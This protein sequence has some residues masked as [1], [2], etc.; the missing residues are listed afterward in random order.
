MDPMGGLAPFASVEDLSDEPD[1]PKHRLTLPGVR[2]EMGVPTPRIDI[3][4]ASSS[5]QKDD[6]SPERDLFT[7]N[8]H[9]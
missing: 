2:E 9:G 6:S 5:S 1:S 8:A 7:G 4:R 3:S